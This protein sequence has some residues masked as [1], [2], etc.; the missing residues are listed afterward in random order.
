[1]PTWLPHD[2]L[3]FWRIWL[4][5]LLALGAALALRPIRVVPAG[6]VAALLGWAALVPIPVLLR[7]VAIPRTPLDFLLLPAVFAVVAGIAAHKGG[8]WAR[9]APVLLA[10]G[11]GW[12]LA[13]MPAGRAEFWRV[14]V[15][16]GMAAW[17][18]ARAVAGRPERVVL[19]ALAVAA[20]LAV[21]GAPWPWLVAA[22]VLAAAGLGGPGLGGAGLGGAG[23]TLGVALLAVVSL[24]LGR[25][26]RGGL[27]PVDVAVLSAFGAPWV[28]R[29]TEARA[30]R[31]GPWLG[32][33]A[34]LAVTVAAVW[35]ALRIGRI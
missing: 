31:W 13:G 21:A 29:M 33:T 16:V 27:D 22:L 4:P 10:V 14:W 5:P 26:V 23:S 15:V 24:G 3:S 19:M 11:S 9:W 34:A 6:A 12:W 32:A 17:V 28:L 25:L 7:S 18:G 35:L 1:M 30:R 20:G 8:R 2:F